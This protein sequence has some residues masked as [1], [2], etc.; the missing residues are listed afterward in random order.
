MPSPAPWQVAAASALAGGAIAGWY[1]L[2]R[3]RQPLSR[4]PLTD[5]EAIYFGSELVSL[6]EVPGDVDSYEHASWAHDFSEPALEITRARLHRLKAHGYDVA[7]VIVPAVPARELHHKGKPMEPKEWPMPIVRG[8]YLKVPRIE[9]SAATAVASGA[10]S[11]LMRADDGKWYRLKGCGNH[12]EGVVVRENAGG[13]RDLRGVAFMHTATRE[14]YWTTKLATAIECTPSANVALGRFLYS[15]PNAPFGEKDPNM[16]PACVVHQTL[17]DRRL[18][19]HVLAGLHLLLPCLLDA[20]CL[21]SGADDLRGAFPAMRP[22]PRDVSTAQLASDHMLARELFWSG[23]GAD[24]PGLQWDEL[25][26]DASCFGCFRKG[27]AALTIRAPQT[28]PA[29]RQWTLAGAVGMS[30]D[31]QRRWCDACDELGSLLA[32]SPHCAS[33]ALPHLFATLGHECGRFLRALHAEGV[34]WGTYQDTMCHD[35]QWH[36][37]AHSNNFVL[38]AQ[39]PELSAPLVGFLDLDMAFDKETYVSLSEELAK[40]DG[41][42]HALLL[43][44]EFV[45]L[46]EV[47]AGADASAG[48]PKVAM[49]EVDNF[50]PAVRL[51]SNALHDTLVAEYIAAY[52]GEPSAMSE[53]SSQVDGTLLAKCNHA[54]ARCAVIVMARCEA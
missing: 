30:P 48:V 24:A 10:R 21:S 39:A 11:A 25:P 34:S 8:P 20:A 17:G 47:L 26:R 53:I 36:C 33:C 14:L 3:R 2:R 45:N 16:R 38:L 37:N 5:F 32:A 19:T 42:S 35:G 15:A 22:D 6:A 27:S 13:W 1:W 49:R 7:D 40:I 44:R 46:L 54:L 29:P 50:S 4:L 9:K 31:W 28:T 52:R 12:D 23:I 51:A 41:A 43:E 18:G